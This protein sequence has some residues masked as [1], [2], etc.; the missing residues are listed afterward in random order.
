MARYFVVF[1]MRRGG[2]HGIIHWICSQAR[3]AIHY[4][5]NEY[6]K[7]N[8]FAD[9]NPVIYPKTGGRHVGS[10]P[11][12]H[13]C[14]NVVLYNFEDRRIS[15]YKDRLLA[16][17][18][19]EDVT[20]IVI[21]RDPYNLYASRRKDSKK[22]KEALY[23]EHMNYYEQKDIVGINF[24]KWFS[25]KEYRKR[26]AEKLDIEFTDEGLNKAVH[27]QAGP[28]SFDKDRYRDNAQQMNVL[29]RYNQINPKGVFDKFPSAIKKFAKKHFNMEISG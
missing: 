22:W 25:D 21:L 13:S 28:S 24:N 9:R 6:S 23:L 12:G 18:K 14:Y 8:K 2:Q 17:F 15:I 20:F 27:P 10:K 3:P 1:C 16:R 4:N 7:K 26:L 11:D 19:E 5:N 29:G